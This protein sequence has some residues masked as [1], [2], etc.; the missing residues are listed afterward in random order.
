MFFRLKQFHKK[1]HT[2]L[3]LAETII[4]AII[5]LVLACLARVETI[6]QDELILQQYSLNFKN[7]NTPQYF[8]VILGFIEIVSI[9][10]IIGLKNMKNPIFAK[11][12][13]HILFFFSLLILAV[14]VVVAIFFS[15]YTIVVDNGG[16]A[17]QAINYNHTLASFITCVLQA[18][19]CLD[20]NMWRSDFGLEKYYG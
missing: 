8:P 11:K 10:I 2:W 4:I 1:Y 7:M 6:E 15:N 18:L 16:T 17:S 3:L 5:I 14:D 19:I 20:I 13:V 9:M 12:C